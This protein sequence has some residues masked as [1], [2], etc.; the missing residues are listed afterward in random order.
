M[1][2]LLSK[3]SVLGILIAGLV[4]VLCPAPAGAAAPSK[5]KADNTR[6]YNSVTGQAFT[7]RGANYVRLAKDADGVVYH[8]TFEP[9]KYKLTAVRDF[10]NQLKLYKYNTV[11]VFIDPGSVNV[12]TAHGIGRGMGT[13]DTVY[14]PYMDNVAS[15]VNEAAARGIYV[16][17]SMDMFPQNTYYWVQVAGANADGF[18]NTN[19]AGRNS[20]YMSRTHVMAKAEYMKQFAQALISR[21]GANESAILAYQADNEVFYETSQAPFHQLSGSVRPVDGLVYDM[22]KPADRQQAADASMVVYSQLI[23][24]K[25]LEASPNALMTMGFFTNLAV[26]KTSYNGLITSYCSTNCQPGIDYRVPG[27]PSA[28]SAW[29]K[30][31][32]LDIHIYPD[33]NPFSLTKTLNSIEETWFQKPYIIGEFGA[34]KSVY[35]NNITTAANAM[36][37]LQTATCNEGAKGWLFWTWD[38]TENL[39]SQPLFFNMKDG[40]GRLNTSLSPIYRSNPCSASNTNIQYIRK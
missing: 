25:L 30:A 35:S 17:P 32:F 13:Y 24:Q 29:G 38:T 7:P 2:T 3:L 37:D 15:F 18:S 26:G 31:D 5:I 16:L 8:S 12:N 6:L 33:T 40:Q 34:L 11:R 22:S 36:R 23:K 10:L 1:K 21:V 28:L 14:G 27:R 20:D 39:A 19:V 4:F 9:G